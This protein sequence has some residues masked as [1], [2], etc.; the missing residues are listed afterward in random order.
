[1]SLN[2]HVRKTKP[3]PSFAVNMSTRND[4]PPIRTSSRH[5]NTSYCLQI[6]A[7]VGLTSL[8][9]CIY[10]LITGMLACYMF[11]LTPCCCPHRQMVSDKIRLSPSR[12]VSW[13]SCEHVHHRSFSFHA[14]FL[15]VRAHTL[16]CWCSGRI[17]V[18]LCN[19]KCLWILKLERGSTRSHS[20]EN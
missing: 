8:D 10:P 1:V 19:L 16:S 7:G 18:K 5:C 17:H 20:V 15:N 9:Y 4:T 12:H 6:T 14:Q 11:F 2:P 3:L 13:T